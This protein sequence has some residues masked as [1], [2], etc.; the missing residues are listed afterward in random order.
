[1]KKV[2]YLLFS[3]IFV[4]TMITVVNAK[5][6][7]V[8]END[9]SK[10]DISG[11]TA[12]GAWEIQNG[13]L[14]TGSGSGS[15]F[16]TYT[17]PEEYLGRDYQVDLDFVGHTSTGGILIGA[18]GS[19]LTSTPK[20]FFGFDCFTGSAG[21]KA[22][23]GCYKADGSWK[24]NIAVSESVMEQGE[25]IHLTVRVTGNKLTY[26]VTNADGTSQ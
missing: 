20:D 7:V 14:T 1:M 23:L 11:L 24:G 12:K 2:L 22:A 17:I 16:I 18:S 26:R 13:M 4:F 5:E 10:N 25:S 21:D 19:G 9:F 6:I 3:L 8:Y 15:A